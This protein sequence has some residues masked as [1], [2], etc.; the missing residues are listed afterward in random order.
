MKGKKLAG[1]HWAPDSDAIASF[2]LAKKYGKEEI[3]MTVFLDRGD[4]PEETALRMGF[5]LFDRGWGPLDHHRNMHVPLTSAVLTAF[6][7]GIVKEKPKEE[8]GDLVVAKYR[9]RGETKVVVVNTERLEKQEARAIAKILRKVQRAD[10]LGE[11]KPFDINDLIKA[12][13][14]TALPNEKIVELGR[15]LLDDVF[16][17]TKEGLVKENL[18][19]R[20][21]FEEFLK[22]KRIFPKFEGY[23][24]CLENPLFECPC[25]LSEI[26]AAEIAIRGEQEAKKFICELL[27]IEYKDS[28]NYFKALEEVKKAKKVIVRGNTIVAGETENAR[29]SAAARKLCKALIIIQ[30]N[31]RT[32]HVQFH[33]DLNRIDDKLIE[34][35]ISMIRLEECLRRGREIPK[36]NLRKPGYVQGI[37]EWYYYKAPE[38]PGRKQ[39]PGRF[40]LNG[41]LTAPDV[42]PTAIPLQTLIEITKKALLYYQRF[43]WPRW[44]KERAAFYKG[45]S[46]K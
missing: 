25:D 19:L 40:I 26:L 29:F 4:M 3:E 20:K 37:P 46:K 33:F 21:L 5:H 43:N 31:P 6:T 10:L 16:L 34:T 32:G 42:P 9:E 22:E 36:A 15:R 8:K 39:K 38:I 1:T 30:R 44:E 23:M 45:C 12:M 2:W 18:K 13:Q 11:S 28:E 17:F 41:S 24:K 35:L 14:R 27:Q 7:L